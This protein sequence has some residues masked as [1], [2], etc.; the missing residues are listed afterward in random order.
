MILVPLLGSGENFQSYDTP[1]PLLYGKAIIH[2]QVSVTS[3]PTTSFLS[4]KTLF[5]IDIASHP[6]A[7]CCFR[8]SIPPSPECLLVP[9]DFV[10]IAVRRLPRPSDFFQGTRRLSLVKFFSAGLRC[11]SFCFLF[12]ALRGPCSFPS[13]PWTTLRRRKFHSPAPRWILLIL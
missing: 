12:V 4:A 1:S 13:S 2:S 3:S 8:C 5:D 7:R 9:P 11:G 6:Y 10:L